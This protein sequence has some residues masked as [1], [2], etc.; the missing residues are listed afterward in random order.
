LLAAGESVMSF[1]EGTRSRDGRL[2]RFRSGGFGAALEAGADVVPVAIV[3]AGRVLP[4]DGFRVRP[5]PIEVR[6]GAPIPTA[7]LE[8]EGRA[9]LAR[10]AQA[11]VQNLLATGPTA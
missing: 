10:R 1:P 9:A 8:R 11:A 3:G 4:P 7:G 6:V 2:G 5:G